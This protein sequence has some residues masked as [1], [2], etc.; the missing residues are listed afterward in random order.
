[1]QLSRRKLLGAGAAGAALSTL[2]L[3]MAEAL[4]APA[5]TG[6]IGDVGHVVI[7]MQENRSFD[8]Y[9]GALRG[10]RG[11]ADPAALRLPDGGTV[12]EQPAYG[13]ADG[14]HLRPFRIDTAKVNGQ[15]LGDLDHSW[16][17][18]HQ[19][20]NNGMYNRWIPA[21]SEMTMG[22]FGRQ[23]IPYQYA[24]AD[25]FTICDA[26]FSSVQG[27]T[28]PNRLYHWSGMLD[29][30]ATGGGPIIDNSPAR[31]NPNCHWT[32][33]PERLQAAG[34]SW[35]VYSNPTDDERTGNYDDNSLAWFRQYA[36]AKPGNPLHDNAMVKRTL[37]DFAAD[38]LADRL[39]TVSWLVAPYLYCEH[40]AA[41]PNYG[42][43]YVDTALQA[44]FA[45]PAVWEKTAFFLNYDENDG[46][47]DHVVPPTPPPGTPDE[48]VAGRP[49]GLGPR[50]PMTVISPWS[51]GGWVN[52]QVFDHT[53]TLRFLEVL[54]GVREPNI[55]AWRRQVCGDLTS[56]F[57]FAA[58]NT[59][60]PLL[61]DTRRL[62][63]ISDAS[64]KLPPAVVP[65][66]GAQVPPEVEPGTRPARPLPYQV[67]GNVAVDRAT[68]RVTLKLVNSGAQAAHIGVYA[69]SL[70]PFT[71]VQYTVATGAE[72][73]WDAAA[74]DGR[75]DFSAYGPN[76][77]LRSFTGTVVHPE[78][79]DIAIP[80]VAL[81][82][83]PAPEPKR[84]TVVLE[85][86]NA[87]LT[88]AVFTITSPGRS[89]V[90]YVSTWSP[91]EVEWPCDQGRYDVTVTS[92][93][94]DGFRYRFAGFV[95][96]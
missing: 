30:R 25:A 16:S 50:V 26:Y 77:F 19:A 84:R 48:F 56:C 82:L 39:P 89:R 27:P 61:P 92:E 58:P 7:L 41:T 95:E 81:R 79:G 5:R 75:Y 88:N 66:V 83:G 23:D 91:A 53:S 1:M 64:A 20:W 15:Q 43:H 4:A 37:D 52:S 40:P 59:V 71:P 72:H 34:V 45:N 78:Q 76:G 47:F 18:T 67:S 80:A 42:A 33:Y 57:D 93:T 17:G 55:S 13:R 35:K 96:A 21:K 63:E 44:L 49:I 62:V 3:G 9:Y 29:T 11:L 12:F 90:V 54:T 10:V 28:N 36:D 73:V 51:R 60:I 32:T 24:L 22:Y 31:N 2:P 69:D 65:A 68:G 6:K 94:G 8:H 14:R 38:V 74:T 87:G 70:L 85:L 46:Y 86:S